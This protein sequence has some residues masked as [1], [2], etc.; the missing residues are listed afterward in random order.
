M[1]TTFHS[2]IITSPPQASS[3]SSFVSTVTFP[4]VA[5]SRIPLGVWRMTLLLF[6]RARL[7]QRAE[8]SAATGQLAQRQDCMDR[9]IMMMICLPVPHPLP[10]KQY[11]ATDLKKL[12]R[13]LKQ[14][15]CCEARRQGEVRGFSQGR[16][17]SLI[18]LVAWASSVDP[19]HILRPPAR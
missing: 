1:H 5:L 16:A 14:E 15:H 18:C 2:R 19:R 3:H 4:S 6:L 17:S 13:N 8:S 9:M 10:Q 7:R 11:G 12:K